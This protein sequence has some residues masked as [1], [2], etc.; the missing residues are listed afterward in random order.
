[1]IL[2]TLVRKR[3]NRMAIYSLFPHELY[4]SNLIIK[5]MYLMLSHNQ[6]NGI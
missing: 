3:N 1:M 2:G 6:D 4:K 5:K